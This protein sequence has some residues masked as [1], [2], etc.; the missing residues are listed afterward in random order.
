MN[1]KIVGYNCSNG[2][3]LKKNISK[4][5]EYKINLIFENNKKSISTYQVFGMPKI[6]N[7]ETNTKKIIIKDNEIKIYYELEGNKFEY[8]LEWEEIHESNIKA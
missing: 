8:S 2:I 5:N 4:I 7:L 1:I 3:K 6:F